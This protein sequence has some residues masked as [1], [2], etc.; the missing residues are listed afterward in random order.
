MSSRS[1][2]RW[3]WA[4]RKL[5][6]AESEKKCAKIGKLTVF[7]IELIMLEYWRCF[8][9]STQV[10]CAIRPRRW[11]PWRASG[12]RLFVLTFAALLAMSDG[13]WIFNCGE[14]D[15]RSKEGYRGEHRDPRICR[16]RLWI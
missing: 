9:E 16:I 7:V 1:T 3:S 15:K 4:G 8:R 2:G 6:L 11:S 12:K 13:T 5:G 14:P 10:C